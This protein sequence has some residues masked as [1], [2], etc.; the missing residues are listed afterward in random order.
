MFFAFLQLDNDK[1]IEDEE[2]VHT[3]ILTT[4]KTKARVNLVIPMIQFSF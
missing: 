1:I 2:P 3:P 4:I